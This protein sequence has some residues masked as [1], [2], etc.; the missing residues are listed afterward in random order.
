MGLLPIAVLTLTGLAVC[1]EDQ[2]H[3][4]SDLW[5]V[6]I[7]ID[8]YTEGRALPGSRGAARDAEAFAAWLTS[9][10]GWPDDHVRLMTPNA[11]EP[12]RPLR[13]NLDQAIGQWL[14]NRVR[15]GDRIVIY[16]AGQAVGLP[17]GPNAKPGDPPRDYLLPLDARL[18]DLDGTGWSLGD[19]LDPIASRGEHPILCLL[20]TGPAGRVRPAAPE[21]QPYEPAPASRMLRSVQRWPGTT[22]W[23]A[24]SEGPARETRDGRGLFT[25][26]LIEALGDRQG[27]RNLSATLDRLRRDPELAE[28]R[29]QTSGGFDPNL[30][31]TRTA[32]RPAR[33]LITE[34]IVQRG[35]GD[36]VT[37]VTFTP[38]GGQMITA[39][40]DSTVRIWRGAGEELLRVLPGVLIGA[41]SLAISP[42]ASTLIVGGG[43]GEVA[44]YDMIQER[45]RSPRAAVHESPV[46]SAQFLPGATHAVTLDEAGRCAVWNLTQPEVVLS[47]IVADAGAFAIATATDPEGVGFALMIEEDGTRQINLYTLSGQFLR[48]LR[49]PETASGALTL[50]PSGDRVVIGTTDG[51][52]VT[53]G[54]EGRILSEHQIG[55]PISSLHVAPRWLVAAA[56][57]SLIV[58]PEE[59]HN[60]APPLNL[61]ETVDQVAISTDGRRLAACSAF[62]GKILA[63]DLAA[64]GRSAQPI[65]LEDVGNGAALS[66]AVDPGG[67]LLVS[68]D[69]Q[70]SLRSWVLPEGTAR[71]TVERGTGA[72]RH[73]AV[74]PDGRHLLHLVQDDESTGTALIWDLDEADGRGV[75]IIPGRFEFAGRFLDD[76][77]LALLHAPIAGTLGGPALFDVPT[78]A[79][80]PVRFDR[81]SVRN[82]PT[83]TRFTVL[84]SSSD[85]TRLA[86]ANETGPAL[87]CL[88]DTGTGELLTE[89]IRDLDGSVAAL[90][91]ST[92]GRRLFAADDL[93][94]AKVW[95]LDEQAEPTLPPRVFDPAND[96]ADGSAVEITAGAIAPLDAS[97]VLL[98]RRDGRLELWN[99][100]TGI[101]IPVTRL[102]GAV[103]TVAFSP[104]GRLLAAAGDDR[105][106]ILRQV[107]E[108]GRPLAL[109]PRGPNHLERVNSLAFWTNRPILASASHDATIRLWLTDEPNLLGTLTASEDGVSW[110]AY[111]P[112]GLFDASPDGERRV[113]WRI[114]DRLE[115]GNEDDRLAY[116]DQLVTQRHIYGLTNALRRGERPEPPPLPTTRPPLVTLEPASSHDP[117]RRTVELVVGLGGEDIEGLRLYHNGSSIVAPEPEGRHLRLPLT[118]VEGENQIYA[119]ASRPGAIDGRSEILRL[120]C[121]VPTPG[122]LHVLSL[123]VSA[124]RNNPEQALQFAHLDAQALASHFGKHAP[125]SVGKTVVLTDDAVS[126]EAVEDVFRSLRQEVRDHPEDTVVVFLAGH[127]DVRR[128]FFCLL[129]PN[130]ELPELPPGGIDLPMPELVA[131]RGAQD[132]SESRAPRPGRDPILDPAVLPYAEL[133]RQ[134]LTLEAL[135]RLV[136]IDACQADAI[137]DDRG[138]GLLMRRLAD[139]DAY[140]ARTSYILAA[141]R[142]ERA[143][144]ASELEHGLL[145]YSLLRGMGATGL[146]EVPGLTIFEDHPRADLNGDSLIGSNELRQYADLT[147]PALAEHFLGIPL[148][149]RGARGEGDAPNTHGV[150]QGSADSSSA[151]FPLVVLP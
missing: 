32:T 51:R 96:A 94:L 101:T 104:D 24:A 57:S 77:R 100:N 49:A 135:N 93:G 92:D 36:R 20:D 25:S 73:V 69:G 123:G 136:I 62:S 41:R 84:T 143:L 81:P 134:M 35:H 142:G 53:V 22:A 91:L 130:A 98:G 148:A 4:A 116:L 83:R 1:Q 60:P 78:L 88:W 111:T 29:I 146:R 34:P 12:L 137:F 37:A 70:G 59:D 54:V 117:N 8:E 141:R 31:L 50:G 14:T 86:A 66:L 72:V 33:D 2:V 97:L 3:P 121:D 56:G 63:W 103:T 7:G 44:V 108:P 5:A 115:P 42:D 147:L 39:S 55:A 99:L 26:R 82:R 52:I 68:G 138:V 131:M 102:D 27:S 90:E 144:E 15:P 71:P 126:R 28:Q 43:K 75:R 18:S 65:P 48:A 38:D 67:E 125:G 11:P 120:R 112:E 110:V 119:L 118:L 140:Q 113:A 23:L 95:D 109:E 139:R 16:F 64:D 127:T 19:A 124:Y 47:A 76:N 149:M 150:A 114:N 107:S 89:P 21:G 79:R 61:G 13:D 128:E 129:L 40:M 106:I 87:I 105:R 9:E 58:I 85:G 17:P 151:S 6:V 133:Y 132:S 10:A 74:S 45:W 80:L 122:R 145:S 30:S 46:Q